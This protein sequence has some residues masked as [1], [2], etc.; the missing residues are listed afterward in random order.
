MKLRSLV[1]SGAVLLYGVVYT[2]P[3]EVA[4]AQTSGAPGMMPAISALVGAAAAAEGFVANDPRIAATVAAI[5]ATAAGFASSLAAAAGSAVSAVPWV[6]V[7]TSAGL[8]ALLAG[9]PTTLGNDTLTAWKINSDGTV[10]TQK[11]SSSADPFPALTDGGAAWCVYSVCGSTADAAAQAYAQHQNASGAGYTWVFDKCTLQGST[12]S[13]CSFNLLDKTSGSMVT[14]SSV[15]PGLAAAPWSGTACSSGMLDDT[16]CMS[17]VP[18]PPPPPVT[19]SPTSAAAGTSSSDAA[20]TLNPVMLADTV[21]A[22]WL[23]AAQGSG[24]NGLPYPVNAPIL[25]AQAGTI[26]TELGS[27]APTVGS[28][29]SGAGTLSGVSSSA[30]FGAT[31]ASTGAGAS[32]VPAATNPGSGAEVNLGPDPG[33]GLPSLESTPTAAQIL[34]P[35]LNLLPDLRSFSVPA[36]GA[37]CSP[38]VIPFFDKSLSTTA[39]CDLAE[40]VRPE[41]HG[42]MVLVYSLVALFI[43][44]GA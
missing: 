5:G 41:L 25:P 10:T 15:G 4:Y 35:L 12:S 18:P 1:L 38:L 19:G 32:A 3:H 17:Y 11:S 31:G 23:D 24:Y 7:A 37:V 43:V 27:S 42:A 2:A 14:S 22:L 16:A 39:H 8:G 30:P 20:D 28:F 9:V 44:L 33:V 21:N 13:S 34:A 29:T 6:A 40:K 36:H 26:E